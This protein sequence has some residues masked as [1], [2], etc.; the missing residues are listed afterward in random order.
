M[1]IYKLDLLTLL[2]GLFILGSC[3]NPDLIGLDVD[4][5]NG[6]NTSLVDN[7]TITS[8]TVTDNPVPA[9]G[10]S[11]YPIGYLKDPQTGI[12]E[13]AAAVTLNLPS[14]DLTFG[15]DIVLDSAVLVLKYGTNFYGDSLNSAYHFTVH[16]LS[17]KLNTGTTYYNNTPIAFEE[18]TTIGEL[19]VSKIKLKDS[20]NVKQI[21]EG[22]V[23]TF[24]KVPPHLRIPISND[25]INTNFLTAT[26]DKFE[27]AASFISHIKGLYIKANLPDGADAGGIPFFDLNSGGS[28]LELYY[29]NVGAT[30]DTNYVVFSINNSTSPVVAHFSHDYTGTEIADQLADPTGVYSTNFVQGMGGVRTKIKFPDLNNLK[31]LGNIVINKA[32]LE[33]KIENGT[34]VP[35]APTPRLIFYR[36]DIAGQRKA[37]PELDIYDG[38]FIGLTGFGGTYDSTTKI[39]KLVI[40]SYIQDILL[41]KSKQYDAYLAVVDKNV[42][43]IQ[44][45][46]NPSGSI[47]GKAVLGSGTHG[48]YP[49]KLKIIYT[50]LNN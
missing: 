39:Y 30:I 21:I 14:N 37:I 45:A 23:D 4:P 50:K 27:D 32:T 26:E 9:R 7:S 38:R 46:I 22:K 16:Q 10:L 8:S 13:A 3:N 11:Q 47:A 41:G 15:T 5:T 18:N 17:E 42:T 44:E 6:I 40:T 49:M 34:D 19:T 25:F 24:L 33:I 31:E 1:K 2:I 20:V 36:T 43:N 48:T 12:T 35:F 29:R 28:K